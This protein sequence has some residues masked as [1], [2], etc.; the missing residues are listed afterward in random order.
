M[1]KQKKKQKRRWVF[2]IILLV[3]AGL[4]IYGLFYH[5]SDGTEG[6]G[7]ESPL[8]PSQE[9][10]VLEEPDEGPGDDPEPGEKPVTDPEEKDPV[11][12]SE[13]EKEPSGSKYTIYAGQQLIIPVN[14]NGE[15]AESIVINSGIISSEEKQIALTFDAGWL[16]DQTIDLL[17]VLDDYQV[18]A[19]FFLRGKWVEDHPDLAKEIL[20]R[21][22]SVEN[23]SLTHG[24]MK[25]MTDEEVRNE[26]VM[27]TKIIQEVAGYRPYLFRPPF[28][29]Y[30]NRILRI[31][32]QQGYPYT[33]KW[34]VDSLDWAEELNGQ[35]ITEQYLI[36]R[37][38]RGAS[39]K[40]IVLMHVGGYQT[41]NALPEI[42][43]GLRKDGYKLVKVND[44]FP[45]LQGQTPKIYT[46]E[47]GDTLSSI[48]RKY[49]T[50][51]EEIVK[52]N[53]LQ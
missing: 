20:K 36:E 44:M 51:V 40:G 1:K 3:V 30:D 15:A 42:I 13:P 49:G 52:A 21:G 10:P 6:E 38:L 28:G 23:H 35:K 14:G 37:V 39:D 34:T 19:T 32:A 5:G 31:L 22:H 33:V 27:S 17:N 45:P 48:A 8:P 50:T 24:H 12:G 29:E 43:E 2:L 47:K 4:I 25:Q 46:V 7:P 53:S 9:E 26:M 16:F 11:S 41:V 18:K